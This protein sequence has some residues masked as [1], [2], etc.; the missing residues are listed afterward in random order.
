M[1]IVSMEIMP[2]G[3][4]TGL[5][6][7]FDVEYGQDLTIHNIALRRTPAGELRVYSP[8]THKRERVVSFNLSRIH[9]ITEAAFAAYQMMTRAADVAA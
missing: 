5:L 9:S 1:R 6:A 8:S 7:R 3:E 4:R 2:G